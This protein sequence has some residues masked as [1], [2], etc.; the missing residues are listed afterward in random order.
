VRVGE[1]WVH[2]VTEA[3]EPGR[4]WIPIWRFRLIALI[5]LALAVVIVIIGYHYYSGAADSGGQLQRG[6]LGE[7]RFPLR[8]S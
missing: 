8:S 5:L 2:P 6:G 7:L 3:H 1:S 4:A